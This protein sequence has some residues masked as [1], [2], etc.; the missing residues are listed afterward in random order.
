MKTKRKDTGQQIP[1]A[2]E[3]TQC[4]VVANYWAKMHIDNIRK[5]L[6]RHRHHLHLQQ[7][8]DGGKIER[9]D[10]VTISLIERGYTITVTI[11]IAS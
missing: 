3:S 2:G 7:E 4:P 8:E 10:D 5:T 9:K 6:E 1:K 11:T